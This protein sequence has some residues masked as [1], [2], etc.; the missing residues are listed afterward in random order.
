MTEEQKQDLNPMTIKI[1]CVSSLPSQPVPI[2][3]LEVSANWAGWGRSSPSRPSAPHLPSP[4]PGAPVTSTLVGPVSALRVTQPGP[5]DVRFL[6]PGVPQ[7]EVSQCEFSEARV[8]SWKW[9]SPES[10]HY[11]FWVPAKPYQPT[12]DYCQILSA[13]ALFQENKQC[14]GSSGVCSDHTLC[15]RAASDA[16]VLA[17]ASFPVSVWT[18][19]CTCQ[20]SYTQPPVLCGRSVCSG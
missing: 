4:V 20:A 14:P 1:K 5:E 17:H 19:A 12:Q 8:G 16:G 13:S 15:K 10:L 3:E 6:G 9:I 18:Q 11:F 2:R 7:P